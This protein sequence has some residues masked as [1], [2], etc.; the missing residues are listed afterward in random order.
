MCCIKYLQAAVGDPEGKISYEKHRIT[1][2]VEEKALSFPDE[3]RML[4]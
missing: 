2:A 3:E 1:V 4:H